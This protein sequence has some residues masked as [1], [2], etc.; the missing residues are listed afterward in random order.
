ME[1]SKR[2]EPSDRC[3]TCSFCTYR[4]YQLLF[5]A[6]DMCK[7]PNASQDDKVPDE[8]KHAAGVG[9]GAHKRK[10][11]YDIDEPTSPRSPGPQ[12]KALKVCYRT[13][14]F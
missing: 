1:W 8:V 9:G 13:R 12:S 6:C 4:N 11:V 7:K 14:E 5:L 2:L 3:W 10:R